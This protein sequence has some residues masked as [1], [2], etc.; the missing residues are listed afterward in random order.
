MSDIILIVIISEA[1]SIGLGGELESVTDS[2]VVV[3]TIVAWSL[4]LDYARYRWAWDTSASH[5]WGSGGEDDWTGGVLKLTAPASGEYYLHLRVYNSE[6]VANGAAHLGPYGYDPTPPAM[7][8]VTAA[9]YSTS[10]TSLDASWSGADPESGI[11]GYEYSVGTQPGEADVKR[12]TAAG[13]LQS[14]LITG[15]FFEEGETYYVNVR[16]VNRAGLLSGVLSSGGTTI[17]QAASSAG[18][19]KG[20]PDGTLVAIEGQAV[21]A[22]FDGFFY[23]GDRSSGLRIVSDEPVTVSRSAMAD[24]RSLSESAA[25]CRTSSA[26]AKRNTKRRSVSPNARSDS[27]SSHR[28]RT[29]RALIRRLPSR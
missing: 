16:A 15:V 22:A 7:L 11:Q 9:P 5:I 18:E 25:Q 19:A 13:A 21:T 23:I 20:F 14:V 6:G 17:A 12:W 26:V 4:A 10:I 3:V 2:L 1:A 29:A 28:T 24:L 8:S 27:H